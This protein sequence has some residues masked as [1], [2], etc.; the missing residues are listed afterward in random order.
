MIPF[1]FRHCICLHSAAVLQH[2]VHE[3]FIA[4][5]CLKFCIRWLIHPITLIVSSWL[6]V[7][8]EKELMVYFISCHTKCGI[9]S[10]ARPYYPF[11]PPFESGK[12]RKSQFLNHFSKPGL[13]FAQVHQSLPHTNV[14][15][16]I[17]W[18][19]S[20]LRREGRQC[21][22][23]R[24]ETPSSFICCD[25]LNFNCLLGSFESFHA[26]CNVY[27]NRSCKGHSHANDTTVHFCTHNDNEYEIIIPSSRTF[28]NQRL[29]TLSVI[30]FCL[31]CLILY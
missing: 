18:N 26:S 22:Y 1:Y 13:L 20:K 16:H 17:V 29:S 24:I 25:S 7:I 12:Y 31:H 6:L 5:R 3:A 30:I 10:I 9:C 19:P 2:F 28:P 23:S 27:L 14:C 11:P 8:C 21:L 4:F 15:R